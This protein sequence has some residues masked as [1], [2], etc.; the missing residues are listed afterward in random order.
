MNQIRHKCGYCG[1]LFRFS[2]NFIEHE[3]FKCYIEGV[4]HINVDE[5]YV[6]TLVK[7][8]PPVTNRNENL[9]ELLI[10]AVK[11]GSLY[12]ISNNDLFFKERSNNTQQMVKQFCRHS[13]VI[14]E[15]FH[16]F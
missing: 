5:N 16:I 7:T 12:W 6:V 4:D 8:N 2:T 11:S 3:C 10:E 9:N 13:T 15:H 14:I 1:W